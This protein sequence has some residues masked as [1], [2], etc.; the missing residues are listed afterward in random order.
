MNE[1]NDIT[2]NK[3]TTSE[4]LLNGD[5]S[6]LSSSNASL[7]VSFFVISFYF[8]VPFSFSLSFFRFKY[9]YYYYNYD[10]MTKIKKMLLC[11]SFFISIFIF[12]CY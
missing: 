6:S 11:Y 9:Y 10:C 1:E 8:C 12:I 2:I 3:D 7:T 4:Y 5:Y